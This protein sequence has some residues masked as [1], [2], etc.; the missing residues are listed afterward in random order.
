MNSLFPSRDFIISEELQRHR[1]EKVRA[2]RYEFQEVV[3][4][5]RQEM[6]RIVHL[7]TALP[8]VIRTGPALTDFK[9]EAPP[10]IRFTDK[11]AEEVYYKLQ[12]AATKLAEFYDA[13]IA[14]AMRFPLP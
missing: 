3:A 4:P 8:A 11:V 13:K 1:A 5:L 12:D 6:V 2:L 14:E 9:V 7:Y 10:Q